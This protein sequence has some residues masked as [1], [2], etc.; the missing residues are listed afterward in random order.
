MLEVNSVSAFK[1]AEKKEPQ[2]SKSKGKAKELSDQT[3]YRLPE[4]KVKGKQTQFESEIVNVP[5][6]SLF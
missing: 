2:F 5:L 3:I 4:L 6:D 1:K